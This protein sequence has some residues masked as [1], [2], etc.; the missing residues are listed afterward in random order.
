[1][2]N[3]ELGATVP[4]GVTAVADPVVGEDPFDRD[5]LSGEPGNGP[6]HERDAV[7]GVLDTGEL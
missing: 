6:V 4:P 5:A 3:A 7:A 2:S 1:V